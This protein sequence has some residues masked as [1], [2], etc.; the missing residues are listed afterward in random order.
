MSRDGLA[1]FVDLFLIANLAFLAVDIWIAHSVN[2]F[3]HPAEHVPVYFSAFVPVLLVPAVFAGADRRG[4]APLLA[5]AA[6]GGS[7]AV[8]VAGM[9]YH[10][11][12]AY[13]E[14]RTL[15]SLVYSAPFVAPLS[16]AGLGLLALL[17]RIE[18]P[19]SDEWARWLVLL[20]AAG[21]FG[22]F[23][24][25]L[26]DHAQ[27]GFFVTTEWIPV[28][29]AALATGTLL[30]AAIGQPSSRYLHASLW[31]MGATALTGIA[32]SVLHLRAVAETP[33]EGWFEQLVYGAPPFAPL[34]FADL[35]A[36]AALGL[37]AQRRG[38][39]TA[40][41]APSASPTPG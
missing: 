19:G 11:H 6:G 26:L 39:A 37:W 34:L 15:Q 38:G 20:A 16:Y 8:G 9:L 5:I 23:G 10:L 28:V 33:G 21:M 29:V 4:A 31:V 30:G 32:G 18:V 2:E 3:A 17:N 25:S 36:L 1:R 40:P 7:L 27:N 24:L 41:S 13:F 14:Q 22:N 12:G 35:A